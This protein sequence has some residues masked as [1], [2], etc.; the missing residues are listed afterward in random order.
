MPIDRRTF[1]KRIGGGLL[2]VAAAPVLLPTSAPL[3]I[4]SDRLEMGVPRRLAAAIASGT[5][6]GASLWGVPM[7]L[8]QD[9]FSM[10]WGGR[11]PAGSIVT[12]DEVTARR[13]IDNRI[14]APTESWMRSASDAEQRAIVAQAVPDPWRFR[15]RFRSAEELGTTMPI[16][17][18][19]PPDDGEWF[20]RTALTILAEDAYAP[21]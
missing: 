15:S 14:G 6:P 1:L 2:A 8:N 11:L 17:P 19:T 9:E 5:P 4:P 7:R 12:V 21:V 13:W 10:E 16:P 20:R 18:S 3:F